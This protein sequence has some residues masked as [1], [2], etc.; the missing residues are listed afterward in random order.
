MNFLPNILN[1][2]LIILYMRELCLISALLN[3][4]FQIKGHGSLI[5]VFF[6]EVTRKNKWTEFYIKIIHL[7]KIPNLYVLKKKYSN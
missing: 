6:F 7:K 3:L 2:L 4:N 5:S 1:F